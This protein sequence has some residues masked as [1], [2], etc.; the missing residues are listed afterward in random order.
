MRERLS[1]SVINGRINHRG[2]TMLSEYTG[3]KVKASF[4][5]QC[6]N[7][8]QATPNRVLHATGC[9]VCSG[10]ILTK[11]I[12]NARLVSDG[13][14]I[15]MLGDYVKSKVKTLFTHLVC[16]HEW[17]AKP[18]KII[19]DGQ[20]C[21]RCNRDCPTPREEADRL[22]ADKNIT[23]VGEYV[24]LSTRTELE[25]QSGHRW[26]TS[27]ISVIKRTGCP[28]CAEYG[29]N[30]GK[31]AHAYILDF[32]DF[33]KFGITNSLDTRLQNHKRNGEYNV[34]VLTITLMVL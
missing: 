27:P 31:P 24:D 29:F 18:G 9:P 30:N 17:S 8:W 6:G 20:G 11:D 5:C 14:D 2:I 21:P 7:E 28:T 1:T 34:V 23:I 13:R 33:I 16:G 4:V 10:N 15:V 3:D 22:L 12:V 32:G 19:Y 25:C 26:V